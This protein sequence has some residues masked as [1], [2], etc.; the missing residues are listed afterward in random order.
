[1]RNITIKQRLIFGFGALIALF[2]ALAV[3]AYSRVETLASEIELVGRDRYPKTVTVNGIKNGLNEQARKMRNLFIL[4]TESQRKME[5]SSISA[6]DKIMDEGFNNLKESIH[7]EKGKALLTEVLNNKIGYLDSRNKFLSA[8]S[9]D[10]EKAKQIL[11]VDVRPTQLA[12]MQ[13]LENLIEYQS[14][15]MSE[16]SDKAAQTAQSTVLIIGIFTLIAVVGA[17]IFALVTISS[18]TRPLNEAVHIAEL[19]AQGDLTSNIVVKSNDETGKMLNAL[20]AMNGSLANIVTEVRSSADTM[21]RAVDEIAQ[22]NMDLSGRT[23]EQASSLEETA[24]SMEELT[25]AVK[26]NSESAG[27]ANGLVSQ[28]SEI[29]KRGG[30]AVSKVV[31]TMNEIGESSRQVSD[32]IGVIDAIAFQTNI[33][34][35]N[36]AVEAARAGEQGRG[37]A[38]VASEVRSL[39]QRSASAAKE[40]K[41]LITS[42]EKRVHAG[43][44]IVDD[45]GTTMASVVESVQEVAA[46]MN[47]ITAASLEQAAGIEQIN[48]AVVQMD[49][50]T[51]QNAALVE[52]AAAASASLQ[53][54]AARLVSTVSVFKLNQTP[55]TPIKTQKVPLIT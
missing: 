37:F 50:A 35:L 42:S 28:A 51:Q 5:F 6:S 31:S 46:I 13:K 9:G 52:Q 30:T 43:T 24:A 3:L 26:N 29:A 33:L 54:Q 55:R 40:I 23:E 44:A 16:S 39:A 34:A 36:A 32:I 27:R 53:D 10:S 48:Q 20:K 41:E 1:M 47:E 19:V 45:A 15:L 21:A 12:Y 17:V 8:F 18:I 7:S 49:T 2:V 22:G 25:S 14:Q 4:E 38:V 11:L